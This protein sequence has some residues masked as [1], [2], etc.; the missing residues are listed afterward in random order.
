M[1]QLF[2]V[3]VR[4]IVTQ[5]ICIL[6]IVANALCIVT[7]LTQGLKDSVNT[8]FLGL[9]IS[10]IWSLVTLW[11]LSILHTPEFSA[12]DLPFI[13][14]EVGYMTAGWPHVFFTRITTWI[15]VYITIERCICIAAPMK[16][17]S[18]F[19]PKRTAIYIVCVYI[20]MLVSVSPIYYTARFASK[21]IPDKN[22]TLLGITFIQDRND[23]EIVSF[24]IN[25]L[26]PLTAFLLIIAG[27]SILVL[28]LKQIS[29]WRLKVAA[30]NRSEEMLSRD[31]KIVKM[32]VFLST[33]FIS[34]YLPGT[35]VFIWMM[36]D[37]E[38]RLDGKHSYMFEAA[39]ATLFLLEALNSSYIFDQNLLSPRGT[40]VIDN[41]YIYGTGYDPSKD[42]IKQEFIKNLEH[43]ASNTALHKVLVPIRDG[44]LIVRRFYDVEGAVN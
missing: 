18:L 42:S 19:T 32:V 27:T 38:L 21:F 41:S 36:L 35:I 5:G 16:V 44:A 39:F 14:L 17:K 6:S 25:N 28:K 34:C 9:A 12:R 43:L 2:L 10:D 33:I 29:K 37:P 26:L 23:I 20:I 4:V 3:I 11:W 8:G 22:T 30:V 15:T 1:N 13:P 7:F 24:H 40:V 31:T